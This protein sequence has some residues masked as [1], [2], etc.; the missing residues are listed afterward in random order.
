[1]VEDEK[2]MLTKCG[3]SEIPEE[4]V[5]ITRESGELSAEKR[6]EAFKIFNET[7]D[8]FLLNDDDDEED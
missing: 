2:T 8:K 6:A 3:Y 4:F 5:I 1:M 7:I